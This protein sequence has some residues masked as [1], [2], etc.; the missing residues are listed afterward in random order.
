MNNR[1]IRHQSRNGAQ[2]GFDVAR[3]PIDIGKK[4]LKGKNRYPH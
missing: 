4:S 2:R 1:E 3:Q